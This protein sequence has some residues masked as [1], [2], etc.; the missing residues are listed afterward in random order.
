M[1]FT[2]GSIS[3]TTKAQS[4]PP[5]LKAKTYHS[6]YEEAFDSYNGIST[7]SDGNI[8]Y[9]LCSHTPDKGGQMY[10]FTP[11]IGKIKHLGDLN[12]VCGEKDMKAVSQGKSHVTFIESDGK[13]YFS[14]HVGY[15]QHVNGLEKA[16]PPAGFKPYPGGHILSY[17]LKTEKFE[18]L[19]IAEDHEGIIT[20]NMDTKRKM[21]YGL[22]WPSGT[23][24]EYD[25]AKKQLKSIGKIAGA[26]EYGEGKNYRVVCRSLA[27]NPDNGNVYLS[28]SE[29]DILYYRPGSGK[30]EKVEEDDLRKDYFGQYEPGSAGHMAYNWRQVIWHPSSKKVY[31]VHGN[32][33]YLFEFDPARNRVKVLD[34]IT[35]MPSKQ[36][37]M[38]DQFSYGY[39][40]FTLGPDR[41]T[42]YYLT[43][44]PIY[45]NGKRI[46]GKLTTVT[47]EAKGLENL[48]LI[49]YHI[50]TGKYQDHGAIF[51]P[52]GQR[53][54]WV[55]CI[56][57]GKDG[58]VYTLA[59]ITENG[60]TRSDLVSIS[61][62]GK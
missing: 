15:Y 14:T 10:R 35:S 53:P 29:G 31:G 62:P 49:T 13:L 25:V 21:I 48:H 40:G 59:R 43:G 38:F 24:I 2:I 56:A 12:E 5:S 7:A 50:P 57:V 52:D 27:I 46:T 4:S 11:S 44:G 9:V 61:V 22:T 41:N 3:E 16:I 33:G 20:M 55:N 36:S 30:I 6:G 18:N 8:Y 32:S 17:D 45:E 28:N 23:F 39:L 19:A 51:Y 54:T 42:L 34:R 37:G 1:V 26:G 47:G 58:T 60:R